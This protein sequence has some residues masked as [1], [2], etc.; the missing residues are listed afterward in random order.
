MES[1]KQRLQESTVERCCECLLSGSLI[2]CTGDCKRFFHHECVNAVIAQGEPWL[3]PDCQKGVHRCF[4]C[5]EYDIDQHLIQCSVESCRKYYHKQKECCGEMTHICPRHSCSLC[6]KNETLASPLVKC[7]RC[8]RSYHHECCPLEI[9][10]L[11]D[12]ILCIRH[13]L[14]QTSFPPLSMQVLEARYR[15]L[16]S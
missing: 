15:S 2:Q 1:K 11:G 8:E 5:K 3:C 7:L 6:K 10:P 13:H 12:S 16:T 4:H 9:C 14:D